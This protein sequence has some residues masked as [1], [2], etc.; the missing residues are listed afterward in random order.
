MDRRLKLGISWLLLNRLKHKENLSYVSQGNLSKIYETLN[1]SYD[2]FHYT[3]IYIFTYNIQ[4]TTLEM[5]DINQNYSNLIPSKSTA[6][7]SLKIL[8]CRYCIFSQ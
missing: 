4:H 6:Y 8:E 5:H 2:I 3:Y 7:N 1:F